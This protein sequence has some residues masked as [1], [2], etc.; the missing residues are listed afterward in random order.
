MPF[1]T[2][3]KKLKYVQLESPD[4]MLSLYVNTD[5]RILN[6]RGESGKSL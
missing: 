5:V 1:N 2:L 3:I 4:K 6:N